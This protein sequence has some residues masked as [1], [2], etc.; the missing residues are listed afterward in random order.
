ME[1]CSAD[2]AQPCLITVH[3]GQRPNG[4]LGRGPGQTMFHL[5]SIARKSWVWLMW[6]YWC[7]QSIKCKGELQ[8]QA[9]T[10]EFSRMMSGPRAD[11]NGGIM[12]WNGNK[13]QRTDIMKKMCSSLHEQHRDIIA[14]IIIWTWDKQRINSDDWMICSISYLTSSC[15]VTGS[16]CVCAYMS[17]WV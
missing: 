3:L 11:H 16:V 15:D 7:H 9:T 12:N 17:G 10:G 4:R 5:A 2:S 13:E 8:R 6:V 1:L 14:S